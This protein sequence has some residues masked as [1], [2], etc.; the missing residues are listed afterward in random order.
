MPPTRRAIFATWG[1]SV[2]TARIADGRA[3]RSGMIFRMDAPKE[4]DLA[5]FRAL[6]IGT[7]IDL[8]SH[9]ETG[10][11]KSPTWRGTAIAYKHFAVGMLDAYAAD[12]RDRAI[13][14]SLVC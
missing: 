7:E 9:L 4:A 1:V 3:L 10:R 13:A 12:D 2:D 11:E 14:Q 6:G 8:R 5:R